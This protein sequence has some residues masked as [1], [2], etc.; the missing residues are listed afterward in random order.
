M[1]VMKHKYLY[2]AFIF[3]FVSSLVFGQVEIYNGSSSTTNIAGQT[4]N[5][6]LWGQEQE[7]YIYVKNIAGRPETYKLTRFQLAPVDFSLTEKLCFGS[8]SGAGNCYM[9]DKTQTE[10]DFPT[11][12]LLQDN[13]K[14]LIEY[15]FGNYDIPA[16]IHYRYYLKTT[17]GALVDSVDI[18]ASASL[19]VKEVVKTTSSVSVIS[20]PNPVSSNLTI[21]VNGSN[22]NTVKL[23]DVLG[24]TVYVEKIGTSKKID[25][26]NINNGV[27][28]L[29]VISAN[30]ATLQNKRIVVKH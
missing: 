11:N 20:Y 27:Y 13:E 10:Y 30:G 12:L 5:V 9:V 14:G 1:L 24:K 7:G 8:A 19:G 4:I 17:A 15:I 16:E 2:I 26:S 25:L 29:T 6:N 28:I 22:D 3:T 21:N 23:V 18:H